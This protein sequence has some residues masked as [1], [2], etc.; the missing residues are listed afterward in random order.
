MIEQILIGSCEHQR[1]RRAAQLAMLEYFRYP[2]SIIDVI[3]GWHADRHD[4]STYRDSLEKMGGKSVSEDTSPHVKYAQSNVEVKMRMLTRIVQTE[5]N[6]IMIEDDHFLIISR[7]ELTE[8]LRNLIKKVDRE[9]AV[10]QL[11]PRR[12]VIDHPIEPVLGAE[13]FEHGCYASGHHMLF[14]TPHGAEKLLELMRDPDTPLGLESGIPQYLNNEPWIYS[15]LP[16]R[17]RDFVKS[18]MCIQGASIGT[19]KTQT[20]IQRY[21]TDEQI[22]REAQIIEHFKL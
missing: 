19:L 13:D 8:K 10:V 21:R 14:V 5:K 9:V 4:P 12:R 7:Y 16:E 17:K 11:F 2:I 18:L 22:K 3:W 20:G 6:T 15:V 1:Y